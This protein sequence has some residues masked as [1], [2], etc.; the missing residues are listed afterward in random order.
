MKLDCLEEALDVLRQAPKLD[1]KTPEIWYDY[2]L[3]LS[4][5]GRRREARPDL[6]EGAAAESK[7]S[8]GFLR[9]GLPGRAGREARR[10]FPEFEQGR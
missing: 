5:M 4:R 2:G 6:Q 3:T 9:P 8:L 1:P 10:R 7:I